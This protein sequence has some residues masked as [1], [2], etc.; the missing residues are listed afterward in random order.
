M[1]HISKKNFVN[2]DLHTTVY[3]FIC[4]HMLSPDLT[5]VVH[6]SYYPTNTLV[7]LR[8][9]LRIQNVNNSK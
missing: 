2:N 9:L 4:H 8:S 5:Q 1:M 7:Q 6:D 3:W